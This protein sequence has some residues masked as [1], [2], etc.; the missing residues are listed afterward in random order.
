MDEELIDDTQE[1]P[2]RT[3]EPSLE[4]I[5]GFPKDRQPERHG[6]LYLVPAQDLLGLHP[7][8]DRFVVDD[9]ITDGDQVILAG[10]PKSGKSYIAMELAMKL[11]RGKGEEFLLP[12]WT[13]RTRPSKVIYC[14]LEMFAGITA[15]RLRDHNAKFNWDPPEL[16]T[17]QFAFV[18]PIT[19]L[20]REEGFLNYQKAIKAIIKKHEPDVIIFD[21]LVQLHEEEE[22]DNKA[23]LRVLR[24]L[25]RI[26]RKPVEEDGV[27]VRKA[28]THV[29]IHH[30]R[31]P[32]NEY[33]K[34]SGGAET[35]RGASTIHSEA[36]VAMVLSESKRCRMLTVSARGI[37][38]PGPVFFVADVE[39]SF[40]LRRCSPDDVSV[41]SGDLAALSY[42][43]SPA[44]RESRFFW[45]VRGLAD[46]LI[47][48]QTADHRMRPVKDLRAAA[49]DSAL[50]YSGAGGVEF[51]RKDV[52]SRATQ[53]LAKKPKS[54]TWFNLLWRKRKAD[55]EILEAGGN[56]KS[57]TFRLGEELLGKMKEK[58][59][60][61]T[62]RREAFANAGDRDLEPSPF[63]E[64]DWERVGAA[65]ASLDSAENDE[66]S[67]GN[68]ERESGSKN[69]R[70]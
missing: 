20:D 4:P 67:D 49:F 31:K 65:P 1:A 15:T 58:A 38:P 14:S 9:L 43:D 36:D 64:D 32:G 5:A 21:S 11:A 52:L 12:Q 22:N 55:A 6:S 46:Q 70:S 18:A 2:R 61:E 45:I 10:A 35:M 56:T 37:V 54:S 7:R 48:K 39:R 59:E 41:D 53:L 47:E 27:I 60:R 23:M 13:C 42:E 69:P 24:F 33:G 40:T 17:L 44:G 19:E 62:A 16:D 51:S 68:A 50:R 34:N 3:E 26:C 63:S 8:D 57:R 30:T 28:I 66:S 25:R 29:L